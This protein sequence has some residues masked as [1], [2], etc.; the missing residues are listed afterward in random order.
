MVNKLLLEAEKKGEIKPIDTKAVAMILGGI[1][2]EYSKPEIVMQLNQSPEA[3]AN[4]ITS[5][6]IRGLAKDQP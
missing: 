5:L 2:Q 3:S 1:G 4:M 6:I